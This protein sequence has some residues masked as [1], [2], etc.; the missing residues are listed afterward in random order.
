MNTSI[1]PRARAFALFSL[2]VLVVGASDIAG[3]AFST[4]KPLTLEQAQ[5]QT[6]APASS[7]AQAQAGDEHVWKDFIAWFKTAP[8]DADPF[9]L[10]GEKLAKEG[11]SQDEIRRRF[12]V[13]TRM[14]AVKPEGAEVLY[15]RTFGRPALTG[16]PEVDGFASVPSEFV[17]GAVKDLKPGQALDLGMG[18]GRNAVALAGKVWTVTGVDVSGEGVAAAV[19]NAAK[20]GVEITGVK[21]DYASFDL[22]REAWD[23]VVM[24]FA[25]AP[26]DE[27]AFVERIKAA[28]KPGG[29]VVFENFV[30]TPERPHAPM[31]RALP[32]GGTKA[33]F[34]GF[35]IVSCEELTGTGDWGGPGV[36]LVR[37]V[38]RK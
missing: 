23:L 22:G 2:A 14:F 4:P 26:V 10:Y 20:A 25:W 19:K 9:R 32:P 16:K 34:A 1:S 37:L 17:M 15:D 33:A 35:E 38:A 3:P 13:I 12:G 5:A 27:P 18:Q 36:R 28:L 8:T 7:P 31:V 6:G 29:V 30:S 11:L 21:S 24:V